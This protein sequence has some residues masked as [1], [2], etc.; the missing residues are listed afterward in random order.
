M[1]IRR[2]QAA[3]RVQF[4]ELACGSYESQY[5][6]ESGSWSPN[7][8]AIQIYLHTLARIHSASG[9]AI[10]VAERENGRLIGF[11][12]VTGVIEPKDRSESEASYALL[13]DLYVRPECRRAGVA[14]QLVHRAE[15]HAR[16]SGAQRIA[17]KVMTENRAALRF[18]RAHHYVGQFVVMSKA[19]R[20]PAE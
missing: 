20:D 11:I 7:S 16:A 4:D 14:T 12:C 5:P 10:F 13:S 2:Y 18:Y 3:D 8:P 1:T 19:L 17:L 9:G 15:Q 6:S